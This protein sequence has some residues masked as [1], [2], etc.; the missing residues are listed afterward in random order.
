MNKKIKELCICS[1]AAALIC[2]ISPHSIPIGVIS[3]TM[4]LFIIYT[5]ACI[6]KPHQIVVSVIIYII[7]GSIGL[8]VF[9]NYGGGM[10]FIAGITG[11]YLIGYVPAVFVI[12]LIINKNKN[13]LIIYPIAILLGELI[14]YTIGTIWFMF[15]A[16]TSF[17][18]AMSVCVIPFIPFDIVKIIFAIIIGYKIN[19]YKSSLK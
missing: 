17:S 8:P 18:Y 4:S 3:V 14:C 10:H 13:K 12:S 11:G 5:L 2:V 6:L 1:I 19:N 9:S 15:I 7:L 16:K